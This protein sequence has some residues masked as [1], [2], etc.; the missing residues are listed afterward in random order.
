MLPNGGGSVCDKLPVRFRPEI[1]PTT[2]LCGFLG[3]STTSK[4]SFAVGDLV[5]VAE[6]LRHRRLV[7][8]WQRVPRWLATE[9]KVG[10]FTIGCE[11]LYGAG[12]GLVDPLPLGKC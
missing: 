6:R 9:R 2:L 4:E 5:T 7:T 12:I 3:I 10:N 8:D 1:K 11:R